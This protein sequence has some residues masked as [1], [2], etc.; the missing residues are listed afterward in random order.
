MMKEK[1]FQLYSALF[2]EFLK[3]GLFTFGGG[4]AMIS[5]ISYICVEKR[6]WLTDEEMMNIT[7]IAE[8]TPGPMAINCATF[9]GYKKAGLF[10]SLIATLAMVIPSF[11][12]I[13]FVAY[14]FEHFMHIVWVANAF[15]GIKI[16][17]TLLVLDA[18]LSMMQKM[19]KKTLPRAIMIVSLCI[20][21]LSSVFAW[22][23][24]T[25]FLMIIAGL[26]SISLFYIKKVCNKTNEKE[27]TK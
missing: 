24:S 17:A 11:I 16:A 27:Q 18:G 7:V 13:C 14:F 8:S 5:L 23:L 9:T 2:F 12:I 4:Y 15:K 19:K 20:M 3:V 21:F 10:G 1:K 6:K 22:H 25:V 26:F